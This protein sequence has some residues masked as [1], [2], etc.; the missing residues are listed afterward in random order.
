MKKIISLSLFII[1][2]QFSLYSQTET[3]PVSEP[4]Y[5]FLKQLSVRGVISNYDDLIIPLSRKKIVSF[6]NEALHKKEELTSSEADIVYSWLKKMELPNNTDSFVY[7]YN[8]PFGNGNTYLYVHQD[9]EYALQMNPMIS[10]KSLFSRESKSAAHLLTLGGKISGSYSNIGF[11]LF[12]SNGT[13]FGDRNL[14][15]F[16][17]TVRYSYTFNNFHMSFFDNT[18]GYIRYESKRFSAEIGRERTLW[19][20]GINRISISDNPPVFD[21]VRFSADFDFV[22]FKF[23]HGWLV[24]PIQYKFDSTYNWWDKIKNPKYIA[25]SRI[26]FVPFHN[27]TFGLTQTIIY[28]NRPFEAAYLNPFIVFESAQ[29]SL[30]DNDNSF[31]GLDIEYK[32]FKGLE[33]RSEIVFDDI[34][35]GPMFSEGF[36]SIQTR[37]AW[38]MN[39]NFTHPF[40]PQNM[41]LTTGFLIVRPYMYTHYEKIDE[42]TYTNNGYGLGTDLQPNSL[43]LFLNSVFFIS[44]ELTAE[45]NYSH[46]FHGKNTYDSNGNLIENK[47]GYY[48]D[49]FRDQDSKVTHLLAGQRENFDDFSLNLKY[50]IAYPLIFNL[51]YRFSAKQDIKQH[52]MQ[53][54]LI[55]FVK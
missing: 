16:E 55:Y 26:G 23:M 12:V 20:S 47:G 52:I 50:E 32:M 24:Q 49:F 51:G 40:V 31:L 41:L 18:E 53:A 44:P 27:F 37:Y 29:R 54:E 7:N 22:N 25:I 10:F 21:F 48:L 14:A 34:N 15:E 9:S 43:K 46:T 28:A 8:K 38:E 45:L 3:Y 35:F 1:L 6:L 17:K 11:S 42:L 13:Q 4:V 19:G 2:V 33:L 36:G 39:L 5:N 30:N